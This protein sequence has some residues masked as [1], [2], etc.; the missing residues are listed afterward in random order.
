[1]VKRIIEALRTLIYIVKATTKRV[2]IFAPPGGGKTIFLALLTWF[3][4]KAGWKVIIIDPKGHFNYIHLKNIVFPSLAELYQEL[5]GS[6]NPPMVRYFCPMY[7]WDFEKIDEFPDHIEPTPIALKMISM[8]KNFTYIGDRLMGKENYKAFKE[9]MVKGVDRRAINDGKIT[10]EDLLN[11]MLK[12]GIKPPADLLY[13]FFSGLISNTTPLEPEEI[14][15]DNSIVVLTAGPVYTRGALWYWLGAVLD[16]W[17]KWLR[18]T[19]KKLKVAFIIDESARLMNIQRTW[20]GMW[21]FADLISFIMSEGRQIGKRGQVTTRT[22]L[23]TQL[24]NTLPPDICSLGDTAMIAPTTL[25][26]QNQ[27][28]YLKR[29]FDS[30]LETEGLDPDAPP[31]SFLVWDTE[32]GK[33]GYL[34]F[35]IGPLFIPI[36]PQHL[37]PE[38]WCVKD[39]DDV[40]DFCQRYCKKNR[41]ECT[42]VEEDGC[43]VLKKKQEDFI[44]SKCSFRPLNIYYEKAA[45]ALQDFVS[46]TLKQEVITPSALIRLAVDPR[47]LSLPAVLAIW[48]TYFLVVEGKKREG[49]IVTKEEIWD[50]LLTNAFH[51]IKGNWPRKWLI[52]RFQASQFFGKSLRILESCGLTP[53]IDK[54]SASL[55]FKIQRGF[56]DA[57][58]PLIQRIKKGGGLVKYLTK[59]SRSFSTHL[60]TEEVLAS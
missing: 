1:M 8:E 31:G 4:Y 21:W 28:T 25:K 29:T 24:P 52:N 3:L 48:A 2:L 56:V 13:F 16:Y 10:P 51:D 11:Q 39:P 47:R 42:I 36:Q 17:F 12:M 20:G 46:E 6:P 26:R 60:K 19:D 30:K 33:I 15:K 18:N 9:T 45:Q 58:G 5:W 27:L 41:N 7:A 23:A 57:V 14:F 22:F 55:S 50:E 44:N 35:P 49:D 53:M 40:D 34:R 37:R 32:K 54:E 59:K 38:L 43:T